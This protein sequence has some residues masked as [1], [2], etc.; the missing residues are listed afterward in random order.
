MD[1]FFSLS[2]FYFFRWIFGRLE[3]LLLREGKGGFLTRV[4]ADV[5]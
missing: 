5:A 2:L 3:S 1:L 4:S